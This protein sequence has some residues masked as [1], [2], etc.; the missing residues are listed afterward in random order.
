MEVPMF[1]SDSYFRVLSSVS[2]LKTA[3]D[4]L[5]QKSKVP[6]IDMITFDAYSK[7]IIHNIELLSEKIRKGEYVPEPGLEYNLKKGGGKYR[8]ISI[9]SLE[10]RIV[11][12]S[13]LMTFSR[14]EA[15]VF[16]RNSYAYIYG[17]GHKRA[18]GK[19]V[20]L[21]SSGEVT[22]IASGDIHKFFDS[23]PHEALIKVF[24]NKITKDS[25]V[26][27]LLRL[28][29]KN[30]TVKNKKY[31]TRECGIPQGYSISPFL[32]NLFLTDFDLKWK[33]KNYHYIRYADNFIF[34]SKNGVEFTNNLYQK[35]AKYLSDIGLVLNKKD[36]KNASID[37]GF[38]FLGL[39]FKDGHIT[40]SQS[41]ERR[42]YEDIISLIKNKSFSL[43]RL[44]QK[45]NG[46]CKGYAAHYTSLTNKSEV[47]ASIDECFLTAFAKRIAT[48]NR[49]SAEISLLK[50]SLTLLTVD[51]SKVQ[52]VLSAKTKEILAP[53][54]L[55]E[56]KIGKKRRAYKKALALDGEYVIVGRGNTLRLKEGRL[57]IKNWK[58][59]SQEINLKKIRHIELSARNNSLTTN[60]IERLSK[61]NIP[62]FISGAFGKPI[63][64]IIPATFPTMRE[65]RA[66]IEAFY[67]HKAASLAKSIV[68]AKINNQLNLMRYSGK[69]WSKD[70]E[71]KERL[72]RFK[73]SVERY[74]AL[75]NALDDADFSLL[76]EKL[77]GY[78]GSAAAIYWDLFGKILNQPFE[79][80]EHQ[81]A[82][83][84][85]N[86]MLN[87]GYGILYNRIY[88]AIIR[89]HLNPS[90]SYLHSEQKGKSTL[91]FDMIEM[92]RAPLV[93]RTVI[94][95]VNRGFHIETT[96]SNRLTDDTRKE[97]SKAF[98][99]RLHKVVKSGNREY[100]IAD[101]ITK[102]VHDF[103]LF[104]LGKSE[105]FKPY[106]M[107]W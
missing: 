22:D 19:I 56:K 14:F 70:N 62:V 8:E 73:E 60:I 98:L 25:D 63:A 34:L 79:K 40:M 96:R 61:E 77:M 28:W 78:E 64:Q 21:V 12:K 36:Y 103:S 11:Q 10:D 6:G 101:M 49:V 102:K 93:D 81:N 87:Y 95:L 35:A 15:T 5:I 48:G 97:L 47:F 4:A 67:N 74:S 104:L 100:S 72:S 80:R 26:I 91:V 2:S 75:I 88:T 32:A 37:D 83:N 68:I 42:I 76:Q 33:C 9:S 53:S 46:K 45:T 27:H 31:K 92:F 52:R 18:V 99:D 43:K 23:I 105:S 58:G 85:V 69:Y 39:S 86:I 17:K 90:I 24:E 7:S 41:K 106:T 107:K 16:S 54:D 94:A 71:F 3:W 30:G 38:S 65:N 20:H 66:Q 1:K 57:Y 55:V 82:K 29:V 50:S 44:I 89:D 51:G 59:H 13:F 84:D